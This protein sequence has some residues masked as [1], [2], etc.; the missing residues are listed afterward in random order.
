MTVGMTPA[1]LA[2]RLA[3]PAEALT[4]ILAT[5]GTGRAAAR[6]GA[7]TGATP[8]RVLDL[9]AEPIAARGGETIGVIVT[10]RDVTARFEEEQAL[11]AAVTD[12]HAAKTGLESTVG[13]LHESRASLSERNTALERLNTELR[14]LDEMKSNLLANV[15][16]ELHTPLVSIKGYTE[17]ILKRK[18]G[19]LTP[20]QERGLQ[21]ALKNIDR[22]IELIDNLL[23]FARIETGETKLAVEDVALWQL[24]DEAVDL[25]GERARRRNI[26]ITTQYESDDLMVR[27]DRVK[28]GQ[29]FTNLLANAVKFNR[30]GGRITLSARPI[31]GGFVEVEVSDTGIGIPPEEREKIFERFYQVEAGPRRRYEGTG[32]GLAIVRDILRLHGGGIRV[33]STPGEGATFIFTLPIARRTSAAES[34]PPGS[35][36]RSQE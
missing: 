35:R 1:A 8:R 28:L 6:S 19:P 15:S 29:V 27:G 32:I 4:T 12:L 21:V 36:G 7:E 3:L 31:A 13:E 24:V 22:L 33:E 25:V 34:L 14:S 2:A 18:L 5:A 11:R 23:S 16:H 17:M 30:D 20:E 9:A 10:L 26:A